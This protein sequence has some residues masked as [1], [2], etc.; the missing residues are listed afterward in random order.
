MKKE[1]TKM[2]R[3]AST[4]GRVL[5]AMI[6]IFSGLD[7]LKSFD[8]ETGGPLVKFVTPKMDHF[9]DTVQEATGLDIPLKSVRC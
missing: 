4:A 8:L 7:K 1:K 9:L 5:L 6:F 3:L 2:G